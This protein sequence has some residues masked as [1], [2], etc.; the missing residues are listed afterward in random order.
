MK[1]IGTALVLSFALFIGC[2]QKTKNSNNG[3]DPE[4][5]NYNY[6]RPVKFLE[7]NT[8]RQNLRM[9]YIVAEPEKA[10]GKTVLLL[11][12]KNFSA[13][14]WEP[15]IQVLLKK[16]Y[17]VIAPD[18]IGF[19]KSSKPKAYQFTFQQLAHNTKGLLDALKVS[20]VHA[21]GHSMGGM[22]ATR[23]AL[24]FPQAVEKLVLVNPIG[25][26]DWKTVVPYKPIDEIYQAELKANAESIR[27]YQKNAYFA[28]EW[29][30]EYEPLIEILAGWTKHPEYPR[31]AWNSA[32]TTDMIFTQPVVYEFARL[33]T[34][35]LL[36]IGTRDRTAV[37][38]GW[39]PENLKKTLG[40][41]EV[42]G[43]RA[44]KMIPKSKLVE[45]K[46]IGHMPQVE[47]FDR[48]S[49]ALTDFL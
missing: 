8:Q 3:L 46:G 10:N 39:A 48:Y 33:K 28:G 26:E 44:A 32:L 11:H 12:G 31:V 42:L 35:T 40:N 47:A 29:K 38:K 7:V 19:G 4:L 25:L 23:F 22:L 14:Y 21:V 45:L 6:P 16:G 34:P 20:K 30:E 18:Q 5:T 17:R 1:N 43:K 49:E 2:A 37:G 41:Y 36:I 27:E 9:A 15:T 24:M 13:A